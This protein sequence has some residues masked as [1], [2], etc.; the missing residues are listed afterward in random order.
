MVE[1]RG[2][3]PAFA[4]RVRHVADRR[5]LEAELNVVPWRSIA[6]SRVDVDDLRVALVAGPVVPAVA[7]IDPRTK[8]T[9]SSGRDARRTSTSF[10]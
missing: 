2:V 5:A 10:W 9:S 3:A 6:V 8:A 7:Q 4:E 1:R